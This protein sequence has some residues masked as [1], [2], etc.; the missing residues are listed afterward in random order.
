MNPKLLDERPLFVLPSLAEALGLN[1]ALT[2]QQLHWC[3]GRENVEV[4][5]D[6]RRWLRAKLDFWS[7]EFPFWSE[8][9]IKRT[10]AALIEQGVVDRVKRRD[11]SIYAIN[12]TKLESRC[13]GQDDPAGGS[14]RPVLTGQDDPDP[15]KRPE[16]AIQEGEGTAGDDG[17]PQLF[18]A[19]ESLPSPAPT[20]PKDGITPEMVLSVWTHYVE[21]FGQRLR[22]K[23][24]TPA[25]ERT[26]RKALKAV[27]AESEPDVAVDIC[28]AA[29][30]GLQSYRTT[31][32]GGTD[33]S[34]IF[35]TGPHSRSNLTDQIEW[36]AGQAQTTLPSRDAT[37][38]GT[39]LIP[40]D[41]SGVPSVTK[42]RIQSER[43][44]VAKMIA[45]PSAPG[46]QDRGRKALD[47]LRDVV[48]HAPIME[49]GALRGWQ[50]V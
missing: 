31:H 12:Y 45:H 23:G 14:E 27:G 15:C 28:N 47:W 16:T 1:E 11:F 3:L 46:T 35:E 21:R 44:H 42:G 20:P 48:G 6:G 50:Q 33:I 25:R 43:R 5:D 2:L 10:F 13:T 22:I 7:A 26:I 29:I 39:H 8:S 4:A 34:T 49:D 30:D 40:T 24:L 41:L 36:W 17:S 32:P 19:P 38:G 37:A 18:A 9:T